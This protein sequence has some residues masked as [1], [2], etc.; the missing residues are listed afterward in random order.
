LSEPADKTDLEQAKQAILDR[1]DALGTQSSAE[2]GAIVTNSVEQNRAT[3]A[4]VGSEVA[5]VR[6]DVAHTKN[7]MERMLKAMKRFLNRHGV[8]S[9]DL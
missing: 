2:H 8:G 3:R 4:H 6:N 7:F 9:D 1:I 5:T